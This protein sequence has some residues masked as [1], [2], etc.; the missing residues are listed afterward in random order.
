MTAESEAK[1]SAYVS[2]GEREV[3]NRIT[4]RKTI[5][6]TDYVIIILNERH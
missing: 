3:I 6:Q 1:L 4:A 5:T 2:E